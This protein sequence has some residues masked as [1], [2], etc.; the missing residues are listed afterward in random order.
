[1]KH[2]SF[3]L[4]AGFSKPAGY[5]LATEINNKFKNLTHKDFMIHTSQSAWLIARGTEQNWIIEKYQ[6]MFV[7]EFVKFYIDKII[8]SQDFHYEDFFD[9][10]TEL[11]RRDELNEVEKSFFKDYGIKYEY[12][13]DH[14]DL[15]HSFNRTYNQLVANFITVDWPISVSSLK[16][17]NSQEHA[18]FLYLLEYLEEKNYKLHIHTLNHDLLMEKYFQTQTLGNKISDGFDDSYS[19]Y[20]ADITLNGAKNGTRYA[21]TYDIR[22]RRFKNRYDAIFNLYKLHGSVDNYVFNLNNKKYDMIKQVYGMNEGSIYKEITTHF[23]EIRKEHFYVDVIPEFL[24][25]TTEKLRHYER[26]VYYHQVFEHFFQNLNNSK[27]LI[28]IGYGFKDSKINDHLINYFLN[29]AHKTMLVIDVTR[30]ESDIL[31]LNNVKFIAKSVLDS[32]P[33]KSI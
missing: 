15:L 27:H 26:D 12:P 30:P 7:E 5:P 22:L 14:H 9:Y 20:F 21:Y 10:Y 32:P 29:Y 16:P 8:P 1:M 31:N 19:P 18:E 25:G 11:D 33:L 3:L 13:L 4:G 23:G 6:Y 24:S 28:V 2:F 17:Y